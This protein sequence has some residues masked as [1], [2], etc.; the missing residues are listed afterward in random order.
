MHYIEENFTNFQTYLSEEEIDVFKRFLERINNNL[1][2]EGVYITPIHY[3]ENN[4]LYKIFIKI[5]INDTSRY[6]M[7]TYKD[8]L[9]N[10]EHNLEKIEYIIEDFNREM[11]MINNKINNYEIKYYLGE[12][13]DYT[14]QPEITYQ[15]LLNEELFSSYIIF[16][17]YGYYGNLQEQ[18]KEKYFEPCK[19][20]VK[21]NNIEE[22]KKSFVK[23]K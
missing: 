5:I 8:E 16:D 20:L 4:T 1:L 11:G 15:E 19:F 3:E 23:R 7:M 21:I 6:N 17:R 13:I 14:T 22:L 10:K 9:P 18:L 12:S 2:V